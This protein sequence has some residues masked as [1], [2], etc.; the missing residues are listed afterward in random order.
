MTILETRLNPRSP[1][2]KANAEAMSAQAADLKRVAKPTAKGTKK[3]TDP[4][5]DKWDPTSLLPE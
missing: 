2:F 3:K 1:E 5:S 4:A